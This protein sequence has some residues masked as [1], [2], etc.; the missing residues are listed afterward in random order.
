M[1]SASKNVFHL[2]SI[3]VVETHAFRAACTFMEQCQVEYDF[4]SFAVSRIQMRCISCACAAGREWV[5]LQNC[6]VGAQF[7]GEKKKYWSVMCEHSLSFRE[8]NQ[9]IGELRAGLSIYR[10]QTTSVCNGTLYIHSL[11]CWHHPSTPAVSPDLDPVGHLCNAL[12][13]LSGSQP[14]N[15]SSGRPAATK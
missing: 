3:T 11:E 1:A 10:W 5:K 6:S 13:W 15:C 9:A 4:N 8:Q 14:F 12:D 2:H 7:I